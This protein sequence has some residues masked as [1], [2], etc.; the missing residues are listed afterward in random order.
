M[1]DVESKECGVFNPNGQAF[2]LNVK[3]KA[4][5]ADIRFFL[6]EHENLRPIEQENI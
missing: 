3:K 5:T 4:G 2:F 6:W 1:I